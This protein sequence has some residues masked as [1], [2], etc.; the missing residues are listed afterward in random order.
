M[1]R[2]N[3]M[4]S[5]SCRC[6]GFPIAAS[7][8]TVRET[9]RRRRRSSIHRN[10]ERYVSDFGARTSKAALCQYLE[11]SFYS[12][13]NWVSSSGR[14]EARTGPVKKPCFVNHRSSYCLSLLQQQLHILITP[15]SCQSF[16]LICKN[17]RLLL[18]VSFTS[19]A[20]LS[21]VLSLQ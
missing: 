10:N 16:D 20:I 7:L 9:R 19:T 6:D 18:A 3:S 11:F 8:T 12:F 5:S 13:K 2:R 17:V 21:H 15:S 14:E 4:E 1:C